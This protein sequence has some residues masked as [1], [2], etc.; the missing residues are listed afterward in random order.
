MNMDKLCLDLAF[1]YE[2]YCLDMGPAQY[3]LGSCQPSV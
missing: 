2:P 3:K 1:R